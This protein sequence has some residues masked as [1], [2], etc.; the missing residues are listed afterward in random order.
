MKRRWF[1]RICFMLPILLCVAGCGLR[2]IR[3][4]VAYN[5]AN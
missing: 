2:G 1:I 5:D 3:G 4:E